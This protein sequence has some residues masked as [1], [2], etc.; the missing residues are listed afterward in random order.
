MFA[1]IS[2]LLNEAWPF[3]I[4]SSIIWPALLIWVGLAL[5]AIASWRSGHGQSTR[6]LKL[7][8]LGWLVLLT[9]FPLAML[10]LGSFGW[11][12]ATSQPYSHPLIIALYVLALLQIVCA[13]SLVW[14]LR[15]QGALALGTSIL[16]IIWGLGAFF[17]SGF[18]ISGTWP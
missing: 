9:V 16:G 8:Y 17:V 7:P 12:T 18:A 11:E 10:L 3:G 15:A 1:R 13:Y 5:V 14:S 6:G 4:V 2:F